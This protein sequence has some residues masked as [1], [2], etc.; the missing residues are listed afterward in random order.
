MMMITEIALAA[1][2]SHATQRRRAFDGH[3]I[4]PHVRIQ[5]H[6]QGG[7]GYAGRDCHHNIPGDM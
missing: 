5:K 2:S 7:V 3:G 6:P 1:G 4:K